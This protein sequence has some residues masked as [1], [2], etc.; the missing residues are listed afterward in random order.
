[1]VKYNV[2]KKNNVC[3]KCKIFFTISPTKKHCS[4]CKIKNPAIQKIDIFLK[5][6]NK[7]NIFNIKNLKKKKE[8]I[9]DN[10]LKIDKNQ[11]RCCYCHKKIGIYFFTCKCK[12][13]FCKKHKFPDIHNCSFNFKKKQKIDLLISMK[14][15]ENKKIVSI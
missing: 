8:I 7:K 4:I 14:K 15:I 1:M 10:I 3:I 13:V 12:L 9:I 6:I 2:M 5:N 11:K